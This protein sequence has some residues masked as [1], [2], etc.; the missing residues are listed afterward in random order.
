LAILCLGAG[1]DGSDLGGAARG[2]IGRDAI[3][4]AIELGTAGIGCI[5]GVVADGRNWL[6]SVLGDSGLKKNGSCGTDA[7]TLV[8][9]N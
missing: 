1:L 8:F 6:R 9:L 5:A 3:K 4:V 2:V 7:K